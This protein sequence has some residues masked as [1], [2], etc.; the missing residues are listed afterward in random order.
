MF[1]PSPDEFWKKRKSFVK[2]LFFKTKKQ[3]HA[4]HTR[5][6]DYIIFPI[7]CQ[8]YSRA[9]GKTMTFEKLTF[10]FTITGDRQKMEQLVQIH[11]SQK[12]KNPMALFH[13]ALLLEKV[14]ER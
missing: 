12:H 6:K 11:K 8:K 5:F 3:M 14:E 2:L 10:F 7:L 4:S 9:L 1:A 13:N